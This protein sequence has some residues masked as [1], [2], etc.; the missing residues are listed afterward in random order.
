MSKADS[1][2]SVILA[3][4]A[5][6]GGVVAGSGLIAA[7]AHAEDAPKVDKAA[8]REMFDNYSCSACHSLSDAGAMGVV[9]PS[10]DDPSLTREFI[11]G[12]VTNGQGAMPSFSGQISDKE[13]AQLADYIV[14][15]NHENKAGK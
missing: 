12:R 14:T 9:G 5:L 15:V 4:L 11:I 1:K 10:L 6:V 8:A 7:S 13:I 3:A 2:K